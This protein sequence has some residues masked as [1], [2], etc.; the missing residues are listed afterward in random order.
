[1]KDYQSSLLDTVYWSLASIL[2]IVMFLLGYGWF[3]NYRQYERDKESMKTALANHVEQETKAL[4]K[5]MNALAENT[6]QE[7]EKTMTQRIELVDKSLKGTTNTLERRLFQLEWND[8]TNKMTANT[9]PSLA[10]SDAMKLLGVCIDKKHDEISNVLHFMLKKIGEGGKFTAS[11]ITRVN[12]MLDKL[13]T[14]F[15]TL[16]QKLKGKLVASDIHSSGG[17]S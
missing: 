16:A 8:L 10:L 11:E 9:S 2:M 3:T 13:P 5:S 7:L 4:A 12:E 6:S 14:Q 1:M 17:F 15:G